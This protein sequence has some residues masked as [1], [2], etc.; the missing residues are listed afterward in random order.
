MSGGEMPIIIPLLSDKEGASVDELDDHILLLE[1]ARHRL[2]VEWCESLG[3]FEHRKGHEVFGYPSLIAYLKDRARIAGARAKRHVSL[4]RAARRFRS[5]FKSW[6]QNLISTDQAD[7]LFRAAERV[8]D[9]YPDAEEVLLEIVGDTVEETR[10]VLDYWTATVNQPGGG[11]D[12]ESQLLR[13]RFDYTRRADGMVEGE[14][15]LTS[16]AGEAFIT[17]LDAMT[18][19]PAPDDTRTTTQRRHDGFED[20]VNGFLTGSTPPEVGG[21]RPHVNVMVDVEA[22]RGVP[23]GVH[24]SEAGHVLDVEAIQVF[25]CDSSL[26]RIV[27]DGES[28]ILDVGRRTRIIPAALRRAVIARDRHCVWQGCGRSARWADVH[29]VISW[30]D[31]GTTSLDNLCLLC[32]YHHTLIHL[33]GWQ[34]HDVL[35]LKQKTPVRAGHRTI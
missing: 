9:E 26:N 16:T 5:T 22:L 11:S 15:A 32:R 33:H 21:E 13:R 29:H 24:E 3:E 14:F 6:K 7:L 12:L 18:P 31:G 23:G 27:W 19:P 4:A 1:A 10:K 34:P 17:A 2:D 28:E 25:A 8:P 20:L 30:A 35:Q